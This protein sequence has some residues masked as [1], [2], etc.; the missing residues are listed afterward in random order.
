MKYIIGIIMIFMLSG[1]WQVVTET[2]W[3]R[4]QILCRN[5]GGVLEISSHYD[6]REIVE[7]KTGKKFDT[8]E[9]QGYI[10]A[11]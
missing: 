5:Y 11:Q 7:C 6:G 8:S 3:Q 10:G 2:D 9:I 1:C 4:G